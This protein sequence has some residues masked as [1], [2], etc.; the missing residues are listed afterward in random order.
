MHSRRSALTFYSALLLAVAAGCE[1]HGPAAAERKAAL[2]QHQ[3]LSRR[4]L[5]DA[6]AT[7]STAQAGHQPLEQRRLLAAD[8]LSERKPYSSADGRVVLPHLNRAP[9][10]KKPTNK[11][12]AHWNTM[13]AALQTHDGNIVMPNMK[14]QP[15]KKPT[16]P[17]KRPTQKAASASVPPPSVLAPAP[18]LSSSGIPKQLTAL[19]E[20]R[21]CANEGDDSRTSATVQVRHPFPSSTCIHSC[22]YVLLLKTC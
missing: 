15:T 4:L 13:P 12:S 14:R 10:K 20:A 22:D 21:T 7:D 3:Q 9:T 16:T 1:H 17:T 19:S 6:E 8:H 2:K 5:A 18:P 11:P